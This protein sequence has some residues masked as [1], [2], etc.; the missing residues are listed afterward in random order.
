ME[1]DNLVRRLERLK[2]GRPVWSVGF[3]GIIG[4]GKSSAIKRFA[5]TGILQT[6]LDS[7]LRAIAPEAPDAE[8]PLICFVPEATKEWREKGWLSTYYGNQSKEAFWFQIQV[9][10][11]HVE[12]VKEAIERA[13]ANRPLIL[14][15]ERTIYDQ[16]LFWEQQR[17]L[18]YESATDR[19]HETYMGIWEHWRHFIPEPSVLLLFE[20]TALQQT[21]QRVRARARAEELG[22]SFSE[23]DVPAASA[24]EA[25]LK[26]AGGVTLDYQEHLLKLH[27]DWYQEPRAF[28]P[29]A[30]AGGLPCVSVNADAPFHLDDNHLAALAYKVV[31]AILTHCLKK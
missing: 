7:A 14:I 24:D 27:H 23:S 3:C 22:A 9:F 4:V 18:G 11:S 1:E 29:S 17:T 2:Y 10:L 25:P 8:R 12:K 30:P 21:M 20:T 13:P 6:I 15:Q 31:E 28:P 19:H 26:E 16:R 5:K